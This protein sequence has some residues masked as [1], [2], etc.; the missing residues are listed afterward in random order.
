MHEE[1]TTKDY[2][3]SFLVKQEDGAVRV[4]KILTD[5]G[6]VITQESEVKNIPLAY[7]IKKETAAFFGFAR[8]TAEPSI[9][10]SASKELELDEACLRSLIIAG[11]FPE[12]TERVERENRPE[13]PAK[14][15]EKKKET[16]MVTNEELEKKLEEILK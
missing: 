4:K 14:P 3:V 11:P 8:F 12:P 2:E 1:T 15:V 5:L 16:E 13:Q 10:E 7:P 6:A 9:I